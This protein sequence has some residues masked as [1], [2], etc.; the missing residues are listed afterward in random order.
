MNNYELPLTRDGMK[1][2]MEDLNNGKSIGQHIKRY[3]KEDNEERRKESYEDVRC[4]Y[5]KI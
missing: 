2:L 1:R 4:I 3:I 5:E